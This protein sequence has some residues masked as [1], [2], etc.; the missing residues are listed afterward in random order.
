MAKNGRRHHL[1]LGI[2]NYHL[3]VALPAFV[4]SFTLVWQWHT[5]PEIVGLFRA[6]TYVYNKK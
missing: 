6:V 3:S 4:L 2:P 1:A 5:I